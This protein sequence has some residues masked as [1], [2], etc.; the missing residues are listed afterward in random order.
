[1]RKVLI[2]GMIPHDSG[3]TTIGL[4]LIEILKEKGVRTGIS[5]PISGFNGWYQYEYLKS[6]YQ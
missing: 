4:K 6:Q 2:A 5:K 3:K 1:M